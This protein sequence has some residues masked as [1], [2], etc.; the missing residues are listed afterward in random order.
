MGFEYYHGGHGGTEEYKQ[1]VGPSLAKR[2]VCNLNLLNA[3]QY[4][5]RT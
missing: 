4:N 2:R 5:E 1:F 3:Y